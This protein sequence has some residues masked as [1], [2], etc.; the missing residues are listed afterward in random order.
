MNP[1]I[2]DSLYS[3]Y[4]EVIEGCLKHGIMKCIAFNRRGT[5]LAAGCS[6]GSC[7]IWDFMTRGIAKELRD[8][9]CDAAIINVCWSRSG[10]HILVSADDKSLTLWNV[11][12]G[13]KV[14]QTI[15]QQTPLHA[16]LHPGGR[17]LSPP[18]LCLV[19]P[20]S[21][22]PLILNFHT[23]TT[24]LLPTL[25][26]DSGTG[27]AMPSCNN[28]SDGSTHYTPTAACFNKYGDLVY[29]GNSIGEIL[30]ID[31]KTN[32]VCGIF[33]IPGG[34]VIK[35]ITF[36]RNG[37]YLLTNSGDRTSRI[38]KNLLPLK[39]S[40]KIFGVNETNDTVSEI[41]KLK[42]VGLKCLSLFQEF[43]DSITKMHWKAVCFSGNSEFVV[44][45]CASKGEHKLYI[46][47]KSGLLVQILEGPKA[48]IVDLAWHPVRPIVVSVSVMGLAY[49][50]AKDYT[51][52]WSA[53]APDFKQLEENEEYVEQED[54]FDL[55]PENKKVKESALY[56]DEVDITT[57]EKDSLFSDSDISDDELYFLQ[58]EPCLDFPVLPVSQEGTRVNGQEMTNH[59]SNQVEALENSG[60]ED[61]GRTRVK[62]WKP[63]QKLLE[64]QAFEITQNTK[65]SENARGEDTGRTHVKRSRKS[66]KLLE[67]QE[68]TQNTK[69]SECAVQSFPTLDGDE[70]MRELNEVKP[71][72]KGKL[73]SDVWNS[74]KKVKKSNGQI[75]AVCKHCSI[76]LSGDGGTSHLR[77]HIKKKHAEH[78]V[79]VDCSNV[80]GVS[81]PDVV[82]CMTG[83]EEVNPS[84]QGKFKSIIWNHFKK[85]R[86]SNNRI[87]AVCNHCSKKVVAGD[88]RNRNMK[89]HLRKKHAGLVSA[90]GSNMEIVPIPNDGEPITGVEEANPSTQGMLTSMVW[91]HF[92]R[93][94]KSDSKIVAVCNHCSLNLVA[95]DAGTSSLRNHLKRKHAE[96]IVSADCSNSE[97]VVTPYGDEPIAGNKKVKRSKQGML[98]SM[99]WNHFKRVTKS[100]NRSVAVCNHCSINFSGD[101]GTTHLRYHLEKKHAELIV[102]AD[103]SNMEILPTSNGDV[104]HGEV[105]IST[106]GNHME[107]NSTESDESTEYEEV[108]IP[109]RRKI[110][111]V[112]WKYFKKVKK[113]NGDKVFAVCNFCNAHF[114]SGG[115]GTNH[116]R[117]H[118]KRKHIE[119][120]VS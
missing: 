90:N 28:F 105:I 75:V 102:S 9:D 1:S 45:A 85:I 50:W 13:E 72:N 106:D 82:E 15:L 5:F 81:T 52:S 10:H 3:G 41:E 108:N 83:F 91:N 118:L 88:V 38:Y 115:A 92:E 2:T 14:F 103:C 29:L 76:V 67:L 87:V 37:Q 42:A 78:V 40:H 86:K 16:S 73:Y 27:L 111:S 68:A 69:A 63:S 74:F 43:Q 96:L 101:K 77:Y 24:T 70:S 98:K 35:N 4:P 104:A 56:E 61:T 48:A 62:R 116:L 59:D 93:V 55:M 94:K 51:E 32:K 109:N 89:N 12:K 26:S 112:V 23:K 34:A 113:R 79:S 36:S 19:S 117:N 66:K 95:G 31:H 30:I 25:L 49:V 11:I 44:G 18:S 57:V 21:S 120:S 20:F 107:C 71:P 54:E 84:V 110:T 7:V 64:L 80:E 65:A 39:D 60:A 17:G 22:A 100:N 33:P 58:S 46:W 119:L 6:D 47:D 8:D 99:V 53:F 97:N 114:A